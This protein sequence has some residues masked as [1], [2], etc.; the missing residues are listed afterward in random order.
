MNRAAKTIQNLITL[1][2]CMISVG[3]LGCAG[4]GQSGG[5]GPQSSPDFVLSLSSTSLNL[6]GGSSAPIS[7]TVTGTNGFTSAVTLQISGLPAGISYSPS[8]PQV[9]P[10]SS[11]TITFTATTGAPPSQGNVTVT[12]TSGILSH[13]VTLNLTVKSAPVLSG[14]FPPS[15]MVG[16][17]QGG[18]SLAGM[19]FTPSSTVLFDGA[20]GN[21]FFESSTSIQLQLDLSVSAV[22]KSHTVQVSDPSNGNSNVLTYDVYSPQAGPLPFAGQPS[23]PFNQGA[24][25][26]GTL[27]DVNGDGRSDL[28]SFDEAYGTNAAQMSIR[29]GQ[30]DGT[31][32]TP[33]L[34]KVALTNGMPTKVLPGD[35]TGSGH[36]D[37]IL[38]YQMG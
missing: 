23:L 8:A 21:A 3:L 37:L 32:S 28:I 15:T 10:G 5:G 29:F 4:G 27:A 1:P 33:A 30:Q 2:L 34:N 16:V 6:G 22:A 24:T 36:V 38:I 18:I 17:A 35:L 20:R 14:I 31:F 7:V 25:E 26:Q 11:L 13:G 19:N 12:G 9:N